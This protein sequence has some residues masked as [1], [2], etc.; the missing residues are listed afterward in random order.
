MPVKD[1]FIVVHDLACFIRQC[2]LDLVAIYKATVIIFHGTH[3][4]T[5]QTDIALYIFS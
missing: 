3:Q 5:R 1:T 2:L 4:H